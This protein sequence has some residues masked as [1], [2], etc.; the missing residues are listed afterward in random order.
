[1]KLILKPFQDAARDELVLEL[2]DAQ[3][4]AGRRPQAITLAAPTGSG[5][6]VMMTAAMEALRAGDDQAPPDDKVTFLWLSDQ[7]EL[8]VQS[9]RKLLDVSTEFSADDVV[10]IDQAFDQR[11]L[12]PGKVFFLN[13]QKIGKDKHLVT[14]GDKRTFT[15]WDTLR[16][17]I[18]DRAGRLVVIIDEAHRGMLQSPTE[19]K[20]AQS[21]AQKFIKG[22]N[23]LTAVPLVVGITATPKRFNDLLADSN[24]IVRPVTIAPAS[25]RDSGLLKDVI[26]LFYPVSKADSDLTI[27]RRAI[28]AYRAY[29]EA[30]RTYCADQHISE[31]RPIITVQVEDGREGRLSE[32]NLEEVFRIVDDELGHPGPQAFAHAFQEGVSVPFGA[33]SVRYLAPSDIQ[34]DPNVRVVFFKSSLST[35][36]DC[37]RA[38]VMMSFRTARDATMIAQ[39][40][41]RMVRTPLARSVPDQDLLN[42]VSLYLPFFDKAT[43]RKVVDS[44]TDPDGEALPALEV[45]D[46]NELV[47]VSLDEKLAECKDALAGVPNYSIPRTRTVSQVVRLLRLARLVAKADVDADAVDSVREKLCDDLAKVRKKLSRD[48]AFIGALAALGKVDLM[49]RRHDVLAEAKEDEPLD[50]LIPAGS[51]PLSDEDIQHL[52]DEGGRKLREGLHLDFLR[53]IA[54]DG[55]D[56]RRLKLEVAA[57]SRDPRVLADLQSKAG[58]EAERLLR[59]HKKAIASLDEDDRDRI[60][61]V[62]SLAIDPV[63]MGGWE[64]PDAYAVGDGGTWH[65]HHLYI[66]ENT[67]YPAALNEWESA[68]LGEEMLRPG[69]VAWMRNLDRRRWS[70]RIPYQVGTEWRALYPDFVIFTRDIDGDITVSIVDPHLP[71]LEDAVPKAIGMARYAER[72]G[73]RFARIELVTVE[74]GVVRRLDLTQADIRAKVANATSTQHLTELYQSLTSE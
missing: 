63:E 24:R 1:V 25:V 58:K 48:V 31:V 59:V 57:L 45:E 47:G 30:W 42:T 66:A 73:D 27:L 40:V 71:K 28:A 33:A 5:K 39:L 19:R 14:Y 15:I 74:A 34:G 4:A 9:L 18:A 49:E 3:A 60:D 70:L 52:F 54:V 46:G 22:D 26:R 12:G 7:P 29:D 10:V 32:T 69:F 55:A 67:L 37:P 44:L 17:T 6:T 16:N 20:Q 21:I 41:G 13:F 51:D 36:W 68:V 11:T 50:T 64:L 61:E 53:R 65:P 35:G 62:R 43:V 2:R 23:E 8:N 38:E 56:V 72:H